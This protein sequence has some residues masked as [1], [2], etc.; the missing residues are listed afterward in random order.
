MK[1]LKKMNLIKKKEIQ[2]FWE[3]NPLCIKSNPFKPGVLDFFNFYDRQRENIETISFSYKLH[4]GA[5]VYGVDLTKK[6]IQ[7]SY[8][9]FKYFGFKGNFKQASAEKLPFPNNSFDCV[10]SMGVLHHVKNTN[11]AL[12]EIFRI[13]K[14]GGRLILMFYNRNSAK[15]QFRYRLKSLLTGKSM[16][17]LVN[18]FDGDGN[19][20]G[21]VFSKNQL[22]KQLKLFSDIQ[23]FTGYLD[24]GDV[25]PYGSR[26]LPRQ[27]FKFLE[28]LLG[29]NLYV[30]AFKP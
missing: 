6:A 5:K 27:L 8:K 10:C 22:K 9:R 14:P 16:Q 2:N 18:E 17:E 3:N 26:F 7:L 23:M 12:K 15:Y 4:E 30:K 21:K 25:I 29:W 19:P 20:L 28:K 1:K 13:L 24:V 11:K